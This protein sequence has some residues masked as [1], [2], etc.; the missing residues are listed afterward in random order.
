TRSYGDWSSDVCSS[1]L[2][3]CHTEGDNR[4]CLATDTQKNT[5]FSFAR[6]GMG[7]PE[8]FLL[9]LGKHFTTSFPWVTGGRWAAEQHTWRR[10]RRS[11]ERRVG[12]EGRS[13][14]G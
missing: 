11:E 14:C 8:E 7:A 2:E 6:D 1:D 9:R 5:I 13:G 4:H 12:K 3:A 10:I